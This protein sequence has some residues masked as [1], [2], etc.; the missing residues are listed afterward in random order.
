MAQC[1]RCKSF[2][3][4]NKHSLIRLPGVKRKAV[5]MSCHKDWEV[6]KDRVWKQFIDPP[7]HSTEKRGL[8][9]AQLAERGLLDSQQKA[10]R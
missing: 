7:R 9:A 10:N 3:D 1:V 8:S 4:Q 6:Y 2:I 5:C